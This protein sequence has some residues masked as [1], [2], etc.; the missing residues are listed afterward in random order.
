MT[1]VTIVIATH[2][3]PEMLRVELESIMTAANLVNDVVR[4]IVV[5]D[6]SA[7]N[8]A[9][10]IAAEYDADYLRNPTN[11]GVYGTLVRGFAEVDSPFYSFWGDDD[12][13]MPNWF[14]LHLAKIAEGYDVVAGSYW[15]ADATLKRTSQVILPVAKLADLKRGDVKVNDGALVRRSSLGSIRYRPERERATLLTFWLDMAAAG[16]RFGVIEEPTWLYRRHPGNLSNFRSVRDNAMRR[17][18]LAEYR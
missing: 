13:M 2:D 6:A 18:T 1:D 15:L 8:E 7:T 12:Y 16:K 9:Q 4:M 11:L 5:D 17:K 14:E 3:R 10:F